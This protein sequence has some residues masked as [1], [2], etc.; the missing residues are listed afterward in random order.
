MSVSREEADRVL[1][2]RKSERESHACYP[3]RKRKVKCDGNKPCG[4]CNKRKH[5]QICSYGIEPRPRGASRQTS[6]RSASPI[7][8]GP[9]PN[10]TAEQSAQQN[11]FSSNY[12]YSG[13]NSVISIL[14][15]RASDANEVG[16]EVG[17]VLGLQNTLSSYP[18]MDSKTPGD[19]WKSLLGILPDRTEILRFF[20][21]YRVTAYPFNPIITDLGQFE[22]DLC[23]YLNA[24]AAGELQDPERIT[25]RWASDKS[26]G[27][28]SLLLAALAGGAHYSDVEYPKRLELTEDLARRSFHALRLA[29]FLFRPTWM[30]IQALLILGALLRDLGQSDASWCLLGSTVRLGQTMGLHTERSAVHWPDDVRGKAKT[31]WATIVWQDS[32]LCL[33]YDRPPIVSAAG[34]P[35]D[36]TISERNDLSYAET[37]HL[38][39]RIGLD[40]MRPESLGSSEMDRAIENLQKLDDVCGRSQPYLQKNCV[41]LQQNLE[42]LALRMHTSFCISVL[43]RPVMKRTQPQPIYSHAEFLRTRAKESLIDASKSFLD[44]QA[45]SIVPLRSWSMIHTVLSS[46]LLLC[47]WE[48]TRNDLECRNLQQRVF[49]VFSSS[50]PGATEEGNT[51]VSLGAKWLSP[52][53]IRALITLRSTL[54]REGEQVRVEPEGVPGIPPGIPDIDF[55]SLLPPGTNLDAF[56]DIFNQFD[57]SPVSYLDSIMNGQWISMIE[58][59]FW[60]A[61]HVAE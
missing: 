35:L 54:D 52:G 45:L 49:D 23:T 55:E 51:Q 34:W 42:H 48:E 56:P 61:V 24:H 27:F 16:R 12:V 6:A 17:S 9:A 26:I 39:C 30:S 44:F 53:H 7:S 22:A 29:N 57:S 40:I 13:D 21:H 37:M 58:C 19:K 38:I 4:T 41:T 31:L 50:M 18:F 8:P 28:I 60:Y 59:D 32:L 20:H 2:K 36:T 46:C 5:P 25:P 14:R 43:C 1:R 11:D 47:I 15:S 33:C 3:C 10:N